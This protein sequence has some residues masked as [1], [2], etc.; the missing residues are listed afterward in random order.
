[1]VISLAIV[2]RECVVGI[3]CARSCVVGSSKRTEVVPGMRCNN[4]DTRLLSEDALTVS[5]VMRVMSLLGRQTT[6]SM[7]VACR[8]VLMMS[9][10]VTTE[11]VRG[12]PSRLMIKRLSRC[13]IPFLGGGDC[14]ATGWAVGAA[15]GGLLGMVEGFLAHFTTC[16]HEDGPGAVGGRGTGGRGLGGPWGRPMGLW[17]W[18]WGGGGGGSQGAHRFL[19]CGEAILQ[20]GKRLLCCKAGPAFCV[21]KLS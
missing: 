10:T 19:C 8:A 7:R 3:P 16:A 12:E 18:L 15:A 11:V 14:L 4:C 20:Q 17:R 21:E 13:V 1:M 2:S 5:M 9:L 6:R